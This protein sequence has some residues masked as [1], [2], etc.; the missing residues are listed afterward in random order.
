[1]YCLSY[2]FISYL[3]ADSFK[4]YTGDSEG[5]SEVK[6]VIIRALGINTKLNATV[7]TNARLIETTMSVLNFKFREWK[8]LK[9]ETLIKQIIS[10][11]GKRF[12]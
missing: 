6:N 4:L 5:K 3:Y 10:L 8:R 7:G 9:L 11:L 1:M 12:D 2:I